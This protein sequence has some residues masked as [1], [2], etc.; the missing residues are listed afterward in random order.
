V[1]EGIGRIR[2]HGRAP[3]ALRF[4]MPLA[5]YGPGEAI[6]SATAPAGCRA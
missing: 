4:E 1:H 3:D 5:T 6:L 2:I